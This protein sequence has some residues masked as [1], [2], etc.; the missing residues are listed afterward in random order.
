MFIPSTFYFFAVAIG[1][2][3]VLVGFLFGTICTFV[4]IHVTGVQMC[5]MRKGW[6]P[7]DFHTPASMSAT[8]LLEKKIRSR[9][10]PRNEFVPC[11]WH[12]TEI[13]TTKVWCSTMLL[14]HV[15]AMALGRYSWIF[16]DRR[17][18]SSPFYGVAKEPP[19]R[20]GGTTL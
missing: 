19:K 5:I 17:G 20:L 18:S 2:L 15:L 8:F 3:S 1:L 7:M 9:T 13:H 16:W 4:A 12:D 10:A 11:D 6:I 14:P